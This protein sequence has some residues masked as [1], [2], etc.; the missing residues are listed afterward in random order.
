MTCIISPYV[1]CLGGYA[2]KRYKNKTY[3]HHRLVYAQ[4]NNIDPDDMKGLFVM[5]TCDN[6]PCINPEH[7]RLGTHKD[8]M[9]DMANKGR[10]YSKLTE[11]D[12]I[13]IRNSTAKVKDLAIKYDVT[14][15]NIYFIKER[16]IWR[17]I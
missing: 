10:R 11:A 3:R 12:V 15:T 2:Q 5:H 9:A 17:H 14:T 8:N 7:L 4:H 16:K 1:K 13:A 6:P